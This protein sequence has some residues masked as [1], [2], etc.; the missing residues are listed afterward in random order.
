[1]A[2]ERV[3]APRTDRG[4][5]MDAGGWRQKLLRMSSREREGGECHRLPGAQGSFWVRLW[6]RALG[7]TAGRGPQDLAQG[8]QGPNPGECGPGPGQAQA[9]CGQ[10]VW[11][12]GS[13][14]SRLPLS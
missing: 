11:G 5:G 3:S 7:C 4:R 2:V 1:M 12:P 6:G 8:S 9:A 13:V 10:Q 14:G